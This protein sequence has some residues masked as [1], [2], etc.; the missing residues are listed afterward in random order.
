MEMTGRRPVG[1]Y[2]VVLILVG[3][4]FVSRSSASAQTIAAASHES[5]SDLDAL[6][7]EGMQRNPGVVAARKH[8]EALERVPI[9]IRSLPDP[10]IQI[11]EF[12]VGSPKPAAGYET[13]NFYYT[14]FGVSQDIPGPG[15]LRL[16]GDIAEQ[17]A[18]VARHQYEAAQRE[19]AEKI[20]ESYFE[21]FYLTKTIGLLESER[22][23]LSRIEEIAQAR[24]RVGEGQAQD[25]LK[26]QLQAT[27]MLNEIVHHQREMQQRQA[28]LKAA[29][30]RD[31]DSADIVIG[32]VE[33]T[34]VELDRTQLG[35]AVRRRSTELMIDR[36]TEE[37]SEKALGLA[38]KGYLPDFTLGYAYDKTGP[39]F[40]DYYMLTLGAKIPIYFWRKQTPAIEQAALERSAA[41]E[42]VRAHE[43]DA[44]ASAEDQLVAIRASDRMLKIYAQGL[45]PQA[46][47]SM[48]AAL[49]AYRV[50]KVDFQTLISAFVDLLNLHEEYYRA[51]ADREL[52]VAKLEQIVGEVK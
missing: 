34:R 27:R 43:L 39:G 46:E 35:E 51:L 2:A 42:Q 26:A 48:Q 32:A 52:A 9:Q 1:L 22:S 5:S 24:Y 47:N 20:R 44:G 33:P 28:D 38:Q 16:Q 4:A 14:G 23:D 30:G 12:T 31:V 13:S 41:R 11:Q 6:V 45:I 17:D 18:E 50:S 25:V 40:R 19:A 10:Q 37:R 8:W 3:I 15:K 7:M 36:A 21:L 49:A 29:L